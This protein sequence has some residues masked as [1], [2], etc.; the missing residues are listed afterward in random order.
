MHTHAALLLTLTAASF[1]SE[2]L[3]AQSRPVN[4]GVLDAALQGRG[5]SIAWYRRPLG[6]LRPLTPASTARIF[7]TGTLGTQSSEVGLNLA[8]V[9]QAFTT[10]SRT[11]RAS[12]Q[13]ELCDV[14][15]IQMNYL[16]QSTFNLHRYEPSSTI[17]PGS[18]VD[19]RTILQRSPAFVGV[20]NRAPVSIRLSISNPRAGAPDSATIADFSANNLGQLHGLLRDRHFGAAFP[21]LIVAQ[22]D[23]IRSTEE[24]R[25]HLDASYGVTVPLAEFGLPLDVGASISGSADASSSRAK[26]TYMMTLVQP[27]YSYGVTLVDKSRLFTTAGATASHANTLM[28]ASVVFGRRVTIIVESDSSMS[29]VEAAVNPKVGLTF[30]GDQG[31]FQ[32]GARANVSVNT[33]FSRVVKRFRAAFY[34]GNAARANNVITD[35]AK[36][37]EYLSDPS[38][39]T[40]S[41]NTGEV[42]LDYTLEPVGTDGTIGVRSRGAFESASCE[43]PVYKVEV[44]YKGLKVF[45]VVEGLGDSK[46]DLFGSIS[47]NG[48]TLKS[49]PESLKQEIAAG[50]EQDDDVRVV[51]SE[52]MTLGELRAL[53]LQFSQTLKDWE[54]MIKPEY[55]P[56][57]PLELQYEVDN[58]R[59]SRVT[60]AIDASRNGTP[61]R[62]DTNEQVIE[63]YENADRNGSKIGVRFEVYVTRR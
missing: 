63:L 57:Q 9:A 38:A 15:G 10:V 36:V 41:A 30:T 12:G 19:A 35:P 61:V 1:A 43:E 60:R 52:S 49:I 17:F 39:A 28:V 32:L 11:S 18:F 50:S 31:L 21:A 2:R 23:E 59:S 42:P 37:A 8:P 40:L 24:M 33:S 29:S 47:V 26:H 25:A 22:T 48:K 13:N 3:D 58:G 45:R 27:M 44:R 54:V 20:A 51:L 34:G 46:E 53:R 62:L 16:K 56:L 14:E 4:N 6:T 5:R 55:K 7:A